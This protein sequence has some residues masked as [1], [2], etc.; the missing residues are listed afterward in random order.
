M[1]GS[2]EVLQRDAGAESLAPRSASSRHNRQPVAPPG[3]A[4]PPPD[5]R[6]HT[7]ISGASSSLLAEAGNAA[8]DLGPFRLWLAQQRKCRRR[9]R[10]TRSKPVA[11]AIEVGV[12]QGARV[13]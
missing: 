4:R 1:S 13:V 8:A 3:F 11:Q 12:R 7:E 6:K 2:D 10:A 5:F 9:R